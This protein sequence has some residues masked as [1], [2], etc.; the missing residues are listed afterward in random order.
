MKVK[1]VIVYFQ[2]NKQSLQTG[3]FAKGILVQLKGFTKTK[4]H[5]AYSIKKSSLI[6]PNQ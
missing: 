1:T 2:R 6:G 3:L 5:A 4:L